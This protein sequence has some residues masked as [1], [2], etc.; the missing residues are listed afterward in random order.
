MKFVG[1]Q[2]QINSNNR[3]SV[4]LLILF[5]LLLITVA[6]FI[7][8]SPEMAIMVLVA[9]AI[10][11]II[12]YKIHSSLIHDQTG[13]V[14][15]KRKDNSRVYNLLENLCIA[16]GIKMPQLMIIPDDSLNAYASGISEETYTIAL[17]RGIIEKL[18]DDELE[19]VIAHELSHII[20]RD[21]RLMII[22]IIFVG[23]FAFIAELMLRSM[24]FSGR[25]NK[26]DGPIILIAILVAVVA[27]FI[28]ILL[29]FAIS[30]K[31]EFM[32]D[33]LA[34]E[35]TKK[36]YALASALRKVSGDPFIEA[37]NNRD[38]AQLFM[39]NPKTKS[40]LF[41]LFST[42]PPIEKRIA[43]LEQFV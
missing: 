6:V 42:H 3:N 16:R 31:R 4:I 35:M 12:A 10:W 41:S 19:G 23:I 5:P 18:E 25:R 30:R 15:L 34:S 21:V 17:S 43:V 22:S 39:H 9:C 38:V 13:A 20:N 11:F 29:K 28:S 32:A 40:S 27:Y 36:P 24:R 33:A 1:I 37:V 26:N 7:T 14:P 2:Q 8:Q